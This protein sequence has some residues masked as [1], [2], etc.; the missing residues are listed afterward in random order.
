MN[1]EFFIRN[2]IPEDAAGLWR[3]GLQA[4]DWPSEKVIWDK[5]VVDEFIDHAHELSFVAIHDDQVIG[6]IFLMF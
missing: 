4:F 1:A 5:T 2:L 6:F 3:L